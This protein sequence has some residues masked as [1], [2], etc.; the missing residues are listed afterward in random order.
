MVSTVEEDRWEFLGL[1]N[2]FNDDGDICILLKVCEQNALHTAPIE[3]DGCYKA[4]TLRA[5][6]T[7]TF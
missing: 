1:Q 6:L 4:T 7:K 5:L 3:C 2:L